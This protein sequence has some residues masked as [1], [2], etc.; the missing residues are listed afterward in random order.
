MQA[1]GAVTLELRRDEAGESRNMRKPT[2]F[3]NGV[4]VVASYAWRAR[5]YPWAQRTI[6]AAEA[7]HGQPFP[8]CADCGGRMDYTGGYGRCPSCRPRR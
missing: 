6:A 2:G 4:P 1:T 7:E 8:V 3:R 5:R